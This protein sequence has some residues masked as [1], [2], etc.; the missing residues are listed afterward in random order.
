MGEMI[1]GDP[2]KS[3]F[4]PYSF[5]HLVWFFAIT[6]ALASTVKE[7]IWL[8][9]IAVA[10]V[11]ELFEGWVVSHVPWFPFAGR[12]EWMNWLIG[13]SISDLAG[14]LLGMYA[15]RVLRRQGETGEKMP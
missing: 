5:H 12:E 4:D 3:L 10:A 11:W 15:V 8:W 14:Y 7:R 13:D 2:G 1:W 6:V 9:A